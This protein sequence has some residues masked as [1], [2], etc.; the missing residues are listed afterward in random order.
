M[1]TESPM[2]SRAYQNFAISRLVLS[3]NMTRLCS[4][5]IGDFRCGVVSDNPNEPPIINSLG[6]NS[7]E[8]LGELP[9]FLLHLV[10]DNEHRERRAVGLALGLGKLR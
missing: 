8:I 1:L 6:G 7:R 9:P 5:K 2:G 4:P 10:V 3:D